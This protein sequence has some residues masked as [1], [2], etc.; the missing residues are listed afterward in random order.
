MGVSSVASSRETG[1]WMPNAE[2]VKNYFAQDSK[3]GGSLE[4]SNSSRNQ[5]QPQHLDLAQ[6]KLSINSTGTESAGKE[7][8]CE[9]CSRKASFMCSACLEVHYCNL[10]CQV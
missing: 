2:K 8:K 10:D 4:S 1:D 6:R 5:Q 3:G 7:V 9:M